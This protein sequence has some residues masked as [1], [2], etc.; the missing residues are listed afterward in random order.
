MDFHPKVQGS[1]GRLTLR[2]GA[3]VVPT[4]A[5]AV[6]V[7][8][9]PGWLPPAGRLDVRPSPAGSNLLLTCYIVPARYDLLEVT[10][11]SAKG[12]KDEFDFA[13]KAV[14]SKVK[15][16]HCGG[17]LPCGTSNE[18]PTHEAAF[19]ALPATDTQRTPTFGYSLAS[20]IASGS[21]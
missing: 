20:I 4:V 18:T 19:T 15:I 7:S 8:Q 12:P 5:V 13:E 1:A 3:V 6:G 9:A 10:S 14:S 2:A 16:V 21:S 17:H 11:P